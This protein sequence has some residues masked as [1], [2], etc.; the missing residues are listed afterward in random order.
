[1]RIRISV[2]FPDPDPFPIVIGFESVFFSMS[3]SKLTVRENMPA[4]WVLVDP[5]AMKIK[6]K[7]LSGEF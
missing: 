5:L 6:L 4:G 2:I 3:T 1:L 7:V